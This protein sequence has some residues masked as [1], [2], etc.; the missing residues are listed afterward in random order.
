M[1]TLHILSSPYDPVHITN[2]INPFSIS[3]IKFINYM[4]EFGWD[5]IHYGIQGSE[6]SCQNIT[7]L[8]NIG[9]DK[10][11]NIAKYNERAG[12]EIAAR[13]Q[14]GDM[15]I[16]M[17]GVE[18]KTAADANKDLK[19]VEPG[20]GYTV[21]AVFAPY[22]VFV[23]Y[24]QMHMYYGSQK[25]TNNPSWFDA[26]IPN[27]IT[28]SEFDYTEEK[29]DYLLYFGRVIST[30]GIDIAIQATEATGTKLIIAGSGSLADIGYKTTP[31][32]VEVV[33]PCNAEQ[34]RK[35]MAKARAI[36]GPTY[37][38]E[39]FGNMIVEG[40]FS[41]TPA[42][43][44]DWGGFTETVVQGVTGYRCREFKDFV[45]AIKNIDRIKSKDCR[46]WAISRYEDTIVHRQLDQYLRKIQLTDFYRA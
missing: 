45:A 18:N 34:R 27:G 19:T 29:E 17:Y 24:A 5:C 23:S 40:Y 12:R 43:T 7:C 11:S 44:T 33:G 42:I 46:D 26:V 9:T 15:I 31:S 28:P 2:R 22:R 36:I 3:T 4:T 20:I 32:H 8:E 10:I 38:V 13:K 35:L 21:D 16:C 25:M 37:Y 39:P 41:G 30:K 6:V 1:T 14:P